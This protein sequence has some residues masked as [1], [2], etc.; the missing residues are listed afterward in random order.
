MGRAYA[1]ALRQEEPEHWGD[2]EASV[3][4]VWCYRMV[5]VFGLVGRVKGCV[6]FSEAAVSF[7][8]S[9]E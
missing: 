8:S 5:R 7:L 6:T 4:A 1:K 9:W 3:A 2:G